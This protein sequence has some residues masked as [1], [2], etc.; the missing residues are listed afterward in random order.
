M[1]GRLAQLQAWPK[2]L[3]HQRGATGDTT[4]VLLS[5]PE[6]LLSVEHCEMVVS[7]VTY[8]T[9][10]LSP[11]PSKSRLKTPDRLRG[12]EQRFPDCD[13]AHRLPVQGLLSRKPKTKAL[14]K[15]RR[16]KGKG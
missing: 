13:I 10:I 5:A 12:K 1:V 7:T 8:D 9:C 2:V 14:V 11:P 6:F 16:M 15:A 3:L 4:Q